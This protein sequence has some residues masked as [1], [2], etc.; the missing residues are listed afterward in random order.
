MCVIDQHI[1]GRTILRMES[2]RN[3]RAIRSMD[4]SDSSRAQ[5]E[6]TGIKLH[7]NNIYIDVKYMDNVKMVIY[8]FK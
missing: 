2:G 1:T 8:Y 6:T 5:G 7:G 4:S 3:E